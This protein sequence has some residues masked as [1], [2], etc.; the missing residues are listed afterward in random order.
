MVSR[1]C[2]SGNCIFPWCKPRAAFKQTKAF[3][4]NNH[5]LSTDSSI[6]LTRFEMYKRHDNINT[7]QLSL[8]LFSYL[9]SA[10]EQPK[11][12]TGKVQ[13]HSVEILLDG[14]EAKLFDEYLIEYNSAISES[15]NQSRGKEVQIIMNL[16]AG[17]KYM[18]KVY[19]VLTGINSDDFAE[20]TTYT[21]KYNFF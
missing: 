21:R 2:D 19:T 10:P 5:D 9:S 14:N 18:F 17:T 8:T 13:L 16:T 1:R 20:I 15:K 6:F 7:I 11:A 4:F 3:Y 12:R